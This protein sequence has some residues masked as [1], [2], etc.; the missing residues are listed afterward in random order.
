MSKPTTMS[1]AEEERAAAEEAAYYRDLDEASAA[2][3]RAPLHCGNC[4]T[5]FSEGEYGCYCKVC[6]PAVADSDDAVWSHFDAGGSFLDA[7]RLYQSLTGASLT[8]SMETVQRLH[9]VERIEPIPPSA[10][11][12]N[13]T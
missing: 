1:A 6:V 3:R 7:V 12:G 2:R 10:D 5:P 4:G 9:D 13:Q 8:R 11:G